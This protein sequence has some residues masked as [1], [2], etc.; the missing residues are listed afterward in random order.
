MLKK[1]LLR[2]NAIL[3]L[4]YAFLSVAYVPV[5]EKRKHRDTLLG[6]RFC[7]QI[8]KYRISNTYAYHSQQRCKKCFNWQK[9][10]NLWIPIFCS[11]QAE[12]ACIYKWL[13]PN[14]I[15]MLVIKSNIKGTVQRDVS[16]SFTDWFFFSE[17]KCAIN[18]PRY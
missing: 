5:H 7:I 12:K 16:G 6:I 14:W 11:N 15:I 9:F 10:L 8:Y 3:S 2:N 1:S 13:S 4:S 18:A 17:G